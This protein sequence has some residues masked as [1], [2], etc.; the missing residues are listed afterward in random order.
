MLDQYSITVPQEDIINDFSIKT[1]ENVK[2]ICYWLEETG[3]DEYICELYDSKGGPG[4]MNGN[5][6]EYFR[7]RQEDI[8]KLRDE[9]GIVKN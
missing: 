9:I 3:L 4:D 1:S 6:G 2:D 5:D 7:I 8:G